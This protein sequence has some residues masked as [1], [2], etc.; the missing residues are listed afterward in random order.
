MWGYSHHHE[1]GLEGSLL[2][3]V[4][5]FCGSVKVNEKS[6]E[7]FSNLV[8]FSKKLELDLQENNLTELPAVKHRKL[9]NTD[10]ME[11]EA[12][13]KDEKKQEEEEGTEEPKRFTTQEMT[14]GCS[15]F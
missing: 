14:R 3:F 10:L 11:L 4:H 1:W 8:T 2:Q 15:S 7:V 6:K 12:Q 5:D 13:R 9:T